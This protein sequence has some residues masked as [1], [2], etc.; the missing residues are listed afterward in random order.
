MK[1]SMIYLFWTL[2]CLNTTVSFSQAANTDVDGALADISAIFA[3][4][5]VDS[6]TTNDSDSIE[7]LKLI[8]KNSDTPPKNSVIRDSAPNSVKSEDLSNHV[9]TSWE[10]AHRS[11]MMQGFVW[12]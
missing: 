10:L 8:F 3:E 7:L 5:T 4:S 6:V 2:V 12:T 11:V 1:K 9:F